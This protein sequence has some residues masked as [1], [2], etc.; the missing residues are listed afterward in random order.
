MKD[1]NKPLNSQGDEMKKYGSRGLPN[2][3]LY[4][5]YTVVLY[6]NTSINWA[7]KKLGE[8]LKQNAK[9]FM[10]SVYIHT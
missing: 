3:Y 6:C 9:D 10:L 8:K 4:S 7:Y 2:N 5:T 1:T